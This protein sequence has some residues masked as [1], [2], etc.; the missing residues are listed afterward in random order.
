MAIFTCR[1]PVARVLL[2]LP[3]AVG[4]SQSLAAVDTEPFQVTANVVSSCSIAAIADLA[5]G[6]YDPASVTPDLAQ[7]TANVTCTLAT[8][9]GLTINDGLNTG[10]RMKDAGTNHLDYEVYSDVGML[11][12]WPSSAPGVAGVGLGLT[13]VPHIIYGSIAAGQNVPTGSYTDTL[14]MTVTW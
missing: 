1:H 8:T 13:A 3:L 12:V 10:R 11:Q 5:F 7:T 14:T 9:Y 6:A 2:A 4:A